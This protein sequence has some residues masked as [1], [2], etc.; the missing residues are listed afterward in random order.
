[1]P[2][3]SRRTRR[4][5]SAVLAASVVALAA[6]VA[7]GPE[8]AA[9]DDEP[10]V[11]AMSVQ[12]PDGR[13]IASPVVLGDA[14]QKVEVRMMCES[15]PRRER[16]SLV[17]DPVESFVEG[18]LA[19]SYELKVAGRVTSAKGTVRLSTGAEQRIDVMGDASD[20]TMALFAAPIDHPGVENYLVK[21]RAR[22]APWQS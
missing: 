10:V 14:G 11:F 6:V 17:L 7:F 19:Y 4:F 9:A 12:D 13:V 21:R 8:P 2:P 15:D 18:E 5:A 1:M 20:V 22:L 16:M 3:M